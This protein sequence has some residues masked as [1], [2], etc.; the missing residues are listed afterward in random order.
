MPHLPFDELPPLEDYN[1]TEY[2]TARSLPV[3]CCDTFGECIL[4]QAVRFAST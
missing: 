1:R 3:S 2:L 4:T